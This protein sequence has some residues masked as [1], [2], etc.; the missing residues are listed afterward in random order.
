[1]N[2]C[3]CVALQVLS[4]TIFFCKS[5]AHSCPIQTRLAT[6]QATGVLLSPPCLC[7][8]NK[9]VLSC[10]ALFYVDS[11][12]WTRIVMPAWPILDYLPDFSN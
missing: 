2:A 9:H 10:P 3:I 1:M 8:D 12:I 5:L 4:T 6:Q 7:W 11:G